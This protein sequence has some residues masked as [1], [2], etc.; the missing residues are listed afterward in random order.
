MDKPMADEQEIERQR[1]IDAVIESAS[2][3]RVVV[4]GPGTGKTSLFKKAFLKTADGDAGAARGL[5]LTFIR[6]LRDDMNREFERELPNVRAYT[7]DG[8]CKF[9]LSSQFDNEPDIYEHLPDLISVDVHRVEGKRVPPRVITQAYHNMDDSS[10]L[11]TIAKHYSDYYRSLSFEG[12]VYRTLGHLA[13][14]PDKAPKYPLVVVDEYQDLSVLEVEAL[15]LLT[16]GSPTLLAGDDDQALYWFKPA[17]EEH[18]RALWRAERAHFGLPYCSRCTKV[19]VDSIN[20]VV[21]ASGRRLG[22]RIDRRFECFLSTT[23]RSKAEDSAKYPEVIHTNIRG[24]VKMRDSLGTY[25]VDEVRRVTADAAELDE[26]RRGGYPAV[27]VIGVQPFLEWAAQA[28]HDAFPWTLMPRPESEL[29]PL[30]GYRLL[31]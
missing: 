14:S 6:A 20:D 28:L 30:E 27:L 29:N 16:R 2:A 5:A 13:D 9:L 22:S 24:S 10:G 31:E 26:A 15:K 23:T 11:L 25:L 21:R 3:R 1:A 18:L 17:T 8:Y 7:F 12:C 19:V 4:A